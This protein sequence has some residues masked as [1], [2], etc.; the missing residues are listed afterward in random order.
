MHH[1]EKD[2]TSLKQHRLVF[3][4][5]ETRTCDRREQQMWPNDFVHPK[6]GVEVSE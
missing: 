4:N 3:I 5:Q 2:I 1:K 6:S